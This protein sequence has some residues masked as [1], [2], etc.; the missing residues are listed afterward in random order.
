MSWDSSEA[1]SFVSSNF[2]KA[3][4]NPNTMNKLVRVSSDSALPCSQST[5][6]SE[7]P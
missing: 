4:L 1:L 6:D 7:V 2:L 3:P 5:L